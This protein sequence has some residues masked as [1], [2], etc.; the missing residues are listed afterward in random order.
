LAAETLAYEGWEGLDFL[1][2]SR[3]NRAFSMGYAGFSL[4]EI[5]RALLPPSRTVGTGAH[6]FGLAE[7]AG[8]VMG[9]NVIQFLLFC[10]KLLSEPFP[11]GRLHPKQLAPV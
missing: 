4:N 3:P 5:S 7:R 6:D 9:A 8:F 11:S 1:G 10:N 2:F